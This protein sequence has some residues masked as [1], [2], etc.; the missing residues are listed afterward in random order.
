M[1]RFELSH[2]FDFRTIH[3]TSGAS[4]W[5]QIERNA[6]I[7]G[8]TSPSELK[9]GQTGLTWPN[10]LVSESIADPNLTEWPTDGPENRLE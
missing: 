9:L 10:G 3:P 5:I 6:A 7:G 1:T 8:G 4:D 2:S